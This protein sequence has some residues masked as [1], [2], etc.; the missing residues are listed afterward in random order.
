M[1][2]PQARPPAPRGSTA[3]LRLRSATP[4]PHWLEHSPQAPHGRMRQSRGGGCASLYAAV[5]AF[6][7]FAFAAAAFAIT[8]A[9]AAAATA[10]SS[11]RE[12][13]GAAVYTTILPAA[14]GRAAVVWCAAAR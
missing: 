4:P 1:A 14:A 5:A 8:F 12:G 10:A 3:M 9:A 6:A 11:A 7:A 2:A 13:V